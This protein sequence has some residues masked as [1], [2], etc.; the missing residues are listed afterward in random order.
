MSVAIVAGLLFVAL[1]VGVALHPAPFFF[2]RPIEVAVQSV[3][4]QA[5]AWFNSFV[6]AF[7]GFVGLGVGAGV[8][9]DHLPALPARHAT[10]GLL[11]HLLRCLQRREH[12]DSPAAAHGCRAHDVQTDRIQL[13]ERARGVLRLAERAGDGALGPQASASSLHRVLV[14]RRDARGRRRT[15]PHLRRRPLAKRRHRWLSRWRC[16]DMPEPLARKAFEACVRGRPPA[17][18]RYC[19]SFN[20]R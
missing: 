16:V 12:H 13:S 9:V 3:N 1:S 4:G 17:A 11:R 5:F 10:G 20:Q 8:I 14:S 15:Q 7:S 19:C 6:S 2:D 18:A